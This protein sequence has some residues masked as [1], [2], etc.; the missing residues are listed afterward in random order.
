MRFKKTTV[1]FVLQAFLLWWL[2]FSL[3]SNMSGTGDQ[4]TSE[5]ESLFVRSVASFCGRDE[6]SVCVQ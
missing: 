2:G 4:R 5:S 1:L 6:K 3:E